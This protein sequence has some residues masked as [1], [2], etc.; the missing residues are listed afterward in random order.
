MGDRN[1]GEINDRVYKLLK[2]ISHRLDGIFNYE[3]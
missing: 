2:S 1:I 3:Y